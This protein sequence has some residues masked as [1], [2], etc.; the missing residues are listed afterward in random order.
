MENGIKYLLFE[1]NFNAWFRTINTNV[2]QRLCGIK[3]VSI[4]EAQT[5]LL[6]TPKFIVEQ[7]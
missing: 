1:C 5:L 4:S 7:D 6:T 2:G 3:P